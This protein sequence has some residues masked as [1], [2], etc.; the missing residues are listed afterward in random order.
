MQD[1]LQIAR[2]LREIGRLL[3]LK[4]ENPFKARAY[5]R[6]ARALEQLQADLDT[7]VKNG[8]L[9]EIGGIGS[10]LATVIE[11]LHRTGRCALLEQVREELPAGALELSAVPGLNLK[12]IVALHDALKITNVA[13]LKAACKKGRVG[14]IKG[15]GQKTEAKILAAIEKLEKREERM[16]LDHALEEAERLLEHVRSLP[17]VVAAD[18][19]GAL[20]R[21]K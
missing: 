9:T 6:G 20:R 16:L 19:A 7:V 14:K 2:A 11:E 18:V 8:Q 1:R 3:E 4:G 12:R 13:D 10:A 17:E 21:R 15:F 5:E